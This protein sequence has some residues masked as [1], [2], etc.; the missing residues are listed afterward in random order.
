M[1]ICKTLGFSILK[2]SPQ[3]VNAVNFEL[4]NVLIGQVV[5]QD[6]CNTLV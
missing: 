5:K 6:E 2:I 1:G 4:C 3:Q